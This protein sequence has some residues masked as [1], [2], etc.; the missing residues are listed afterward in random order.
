ME[1]VGS[2]LNEPSDTMELGSSTYP[3]EID[4][5]SS[6]NMHS[7]I[8]SGYGWRCHTCGKNFS[9]K[10]NL[11]RHTKICV[12]KQNTSRRGS[13]TTP[14]MWV[15]DQCNKSYKHLSSLQRHKERCSAQQCT[16]CGRINVTHAVHSS[17]LKVC[18]QFQC[19][20]CNATFNSSR[21]LLTHQ[22]RVHT[23]A[24]L[25]RREP[26]PS[27][28]DDDQND[29]IHTAQQIACRLCNCPFP[30]RRVLY[31]HQMQQHG[32]VY[33]EQA[34]PWGDGRAPWEGEDG[35]VDVDMREVYLSNAAH[36]LRSHQNTAPVDRQYNFPSNDL[37]GG[38]DEIMKTSMTSTMRRHM[39]LK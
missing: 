13:T 16:R 19:T 30:N 36:I 1:V 14:P 9:Q 2:W 34:K 7:Q 18:G 39:L 38:V 10:S 24:P 15:C 33:E 22:T 26:H 3:I 5:A 28:D 29:Y 27:D 21:E 25:L 23:Q 32:G 8:G 35:V 37:S 31:L 6:S 4:S 20:L 11:R 12:K 17:H